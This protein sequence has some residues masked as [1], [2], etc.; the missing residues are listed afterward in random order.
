MDL[1]NDGYTD[2]VSGGNQFDFIP[3][4]ERLD[5][6]NGDVLLNDGKGNFKWLEATETGLDL[7]G[8]L[9]DI[10]ELDSKNKKYLLFLQN[11]E[12]PV[13]YELNRISKEKAQ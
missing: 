11:D 7:K 2:I 9:R 12:Y 5:A 6:S 10:V 1:N 4:L 8:E 3:Q 13:L